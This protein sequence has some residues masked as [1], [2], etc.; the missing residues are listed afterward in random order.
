M[1]RTLASVILQ[2]TFSFIVKKQHHTYK[3]HFYI[4][5]PVKEFETLR[6]NPSAKTYIITALLELLHKKTFSSITVIE[7]VKKA[8]ISRSTFYVYYYDK[9]DLLEQLSKDIINKFL[10]FYPQD[11]GIDNKHEKID[12]TTRDICNHVYTYQSFYKEQFQNPQFI[13]QLSRQLSAALMNVYGHKSYAS[14][15]SYG[16]VGFLAEWVYDSFQL[17]PEEAAAELSKIGTTD[18]SVAYLPD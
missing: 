12:Q 11:R 5:C 6:E 14:F 1:S 10:A 17:T 7:I 13:H 3:R 8:G 18:W 9:Y 4:K 15:S 2:L 16:T